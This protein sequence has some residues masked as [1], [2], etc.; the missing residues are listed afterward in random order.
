MPEHLRHPPG[1]LAGGQGMRRERVPRRVKVAMGELGLLECR[2]P[3]PV[4]EVVEPKIPVARVWE[5]ELAPAGD[6]P[7][8]F[9]RAEDGRPRGTG[10]RPIE[11]PDSVFAML[12]RDLAE[13]IQDAPLLGRAACRY[14]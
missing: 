6:E 8:S 4:P 5:K 9:E 1:I 3:D 11:Q 7:L 14:R 13:L 12:A 10:R 2:V